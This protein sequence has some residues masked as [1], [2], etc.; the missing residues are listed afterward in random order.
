MRRI[1]TSVI[2]RRL[3]SASA[4]IGACFI[5][6]AAV[7]LFQAWLGQRNAR[8]ELLM[9]PPVAY[10]AS[11][12]STPKNLRPKRGDSLAILEIDRLELSVVV[13]EGSDDATLKLGPGHIEDTAYPGEEGNIG[14]T[15]HRDTHFRPLRRIRLKDVITLKTKASTTRFVVNSITIIDPTE[16]DALDPTPETALTI[17]TCYPFEFVGSAPKRFIIRATPLK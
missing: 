13:L 12:I 11:S 1:F 15:G 14:I 5:A 16:M 6:V 9:S 2:L 10:A 7:S 17:V 4:A 8:R 3:S